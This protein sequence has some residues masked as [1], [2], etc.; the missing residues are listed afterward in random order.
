MG[1]G[2]QGPETL[3]DDLALV[4]VAAYVAIVAGVCVESI[5]QDGWF[6]S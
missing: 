1:I 2:A 4:A 3:V 5:L 6:D